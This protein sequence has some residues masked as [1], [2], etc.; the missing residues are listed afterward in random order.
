MHGHT[1]V[2]IYTMSHILIHIYNA[3]L[4]AHTILNT[5]TYI[6]IHIHTHT[7]QLHTPE[8]TFICEQTRLVFLGSLYCT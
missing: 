2:C 5:H 1:S 4:H 7:T 8:L 6:Y 3:Y